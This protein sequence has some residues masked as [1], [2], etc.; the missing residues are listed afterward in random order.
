MN[1][2]NIVQG[3]KTEVAKKNWVMPTVFFDYADNFISRLRKAFC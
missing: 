2:E 3:R 1:W